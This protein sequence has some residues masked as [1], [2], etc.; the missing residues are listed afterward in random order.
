MDGTA[1]N[2][3]FAAKFSLGR[4]TRATPRFDDEFVCRSKAQTLA[5]E[6]HSFWPF[7]G[8]DD[9]LWSIGDYGWS[10]ASIAVFGHRLRYADGAYN[11]GCD[12]DSTGVSCAPNNRAN[13]LE[14]TSC[15]CSFHSLRERYI[16]TVV[17]QR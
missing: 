5:V 3:V 13:R 4:I 11:S 7:G 6:R 16:C 15:F 1:A 14:N 2:T 12:T 9:L 8:G 17:L 10:V